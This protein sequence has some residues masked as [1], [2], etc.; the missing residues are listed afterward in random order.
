MLYSDDRH[1]LSDD[2]LKAIGRTG[3]K[4]DREERN[5]ARTAPA[6]STLDEPYMSV[7]E[8][9]DKQEKIAEKEAIVD[10]RAATRA[11]KRRVRDSIKEAKVKAY[12]DA[13]CSNVMGYLISNENLL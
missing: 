13:A 9:A 6:E 11:E 7:Q 8:A 10:E 2:V 4:Q 1:D 12:I 5:N 3:K